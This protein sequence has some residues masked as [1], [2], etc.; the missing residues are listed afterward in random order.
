MVSVLCHNNMCN[1]YIVS[2]TY[3]I[4]QKLI[5][6]ISLI[7]LFAIRRRATVQKQNKEMQY[8]IIP[9][10]GQVHGI[11]NSVSHYACYLQHS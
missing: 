7:Y 4:H 5:K 8:L 10:I 2:N 9:G 11:S 3:S 6:I 1:K